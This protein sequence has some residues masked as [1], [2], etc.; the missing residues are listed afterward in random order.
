MAKQ[1]FYTFLDDL[2]LLKKLLDDRKN[3]EELWAE[4]VRRFTKLILKIAWQYE[5][6]KEKVMDKYLWVLTKLSAND[7]AILCKFNNNSAKQTPKFTTWL[8]VVIN[9]LCIDEHRSSHGRR[10][11]PKALTQM[12]EKERK[13]FELYYWKNY[14]VEE[15]SHTLSLDLNVVGDILEKINET[16]TGHRNNAI[17]VNKVEFTLLNEFNIPSDF[18]NNENE[19]E[20]LMEE[21][22]SKLTT[23]EQTVIRL[24]FWEDLSVKDIAQITGFNNEQKIYTLLRNAL[25]TLRRESEADL[26]N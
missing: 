12:I 14:S 2:S 26:I 21:W 8:V 24:R 10:R 11:F 1:L 19:F 7:Y 20:I 9:N 22:I 16:L 3:K 23:E 15:I 18:N 5:N 25:N 6:D 17:N 4:F 13:I